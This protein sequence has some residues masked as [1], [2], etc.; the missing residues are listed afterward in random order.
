M[1]GSPA[2][3]RSLSFIQSWPQP[4]L[5]KIAVAGPDVVLAHVLLLECGADVGQ[6]EFLPR[7]HHAP[8]DGGDI[9]QIAVA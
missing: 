6:G 5:K 8:F 9:D 3:K 4:V 7:F 1:P 2:L